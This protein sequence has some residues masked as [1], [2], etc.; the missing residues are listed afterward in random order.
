MSDSYSETEA[1]IDDLLSITS[2]ECE[3]CDA[4]EDFE[5]EYIECV[6][7]NYYIG[8]YYLMKNMT[9]D[10]ILLFGIKVNLP[11]FYAFSNYELSTY[12]YF[13]S[14][15]QYTRK[16]TIE[17]MQVKIDEDG[18]YT[19]VLKTLW[20]KIIQRAWK[21]RMAQKKQHISNIKKNILSILNMIQLTAKR[22]P[23]PAGLSGLLSSI[24]QSKKI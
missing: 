24:Y 4:V 22:L 11:T 3:I 20:I 23:K 12:I 14:G 7:N 5:E 1:E 13:C 17:I 2:E 19:A 16:P 8:S 9:N 6:N 21:K 18:M 15:F 10:N